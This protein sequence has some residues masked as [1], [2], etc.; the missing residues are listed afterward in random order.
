MGVCIPNERDDTKTCEAISQTQW[1]TQNCGSLYLVLKGAYCS[2]GCVS[3]AQGG[4]P[5]R[6]TLHPQ[7][8]GPHV[9]KEVRNPNSRGRTEVWERGSPCPPLNGP[10]RSV[11][12]SMNNSKGQKK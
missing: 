10:H 11:G 6:E 1:A 5:K 3:P 9:N 4:T 7:H 8:K 12:V 2:V